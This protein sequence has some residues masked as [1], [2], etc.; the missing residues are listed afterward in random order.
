[1]RL[2][3]APEPDAPET[4][5]PEPGSLIL[6]AGAVLLGLTRFIRRG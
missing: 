2:D 1:V 5:T 3:G 6:S 4:A